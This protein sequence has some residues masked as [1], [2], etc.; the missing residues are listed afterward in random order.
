MIRKHQDSNQ[1]KCPLHI[2]QEIRYINEILLLIVKIYHEN[3]SSL[4]RILYHA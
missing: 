1:L 3:K 2:V 4:K